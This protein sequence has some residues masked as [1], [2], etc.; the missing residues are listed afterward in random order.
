ML[1]F[2]LL[3][4]K[5]NTWKLCFYFWTSQTSTIINKDAE[6]EG[7]KITAEVAKT[8]TMIT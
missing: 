1:L 6:R 5:K 3:R 4:E 7:T 8:L 2:L